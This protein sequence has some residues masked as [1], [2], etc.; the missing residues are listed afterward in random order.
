M[1]VDDNLDGNVFTNVMYEMPPEVQR[2]VIY[3]L[4]E[5]TSASPENTVL[6]TQRFPSGIFDM[7]QN[8]RFRLANRALFACDISVKIFVQSVAKQ[9]GSLVF[10]MS[11]MARTPTNIYEAMSGPHVVLNAGEHVSGEIVIPYMRDTRA[12]RVQTYGSSTES[13]DFD[14]LQANLLV[15]S[16]LRVTDA[17]SVKL[18]VAAQILNPVFTG[19]GFV[20]IPIV[21]QGKKE[22]KLEAKVDSKSIVKETKGKK[23]KPE[24]YAEAAASTLKSIA[25]SMVTVSKIVGTGL[26]VMAMMGLS[27]PIVEHKITPV[28]NVQDLFGPNVDGNFYGYQM[29]S[30]Q[31]AKNIAHPLVFGKEDPMEIS[32]ICKRPGLAG[33]FSWSISNTAGEL[34]CRIPI[35]PGVVTFKDVNTVHHTP[36]SML[37]HLFRRYRGS[38]NFRIRIFATKFHAGQLEIIANYGSTDDVDSE[39]RA[40]CCHRAVLDISN[41]TIVEMN[42]GYFRNAP[43]EECTLVPF[44][45]YI[46]DCVYIRCLAPLNATGDVTPEIEATVEV[47]SED[48][49]FGVPGT[50]IFNFPIV[51]QGIFEDNLTHTIIDGKVDLRDDWNNH[52]SVWDRF[53]SG[54]MIKNLRQV[55][56][57]FMFLPEDTVSVNGVD[58]YILY[59][60]IPWVEAAAS[61]FVFQIGG[62]RLST[63]SN[64]NIVSYTDR[65]NSLYT[66]SLSGYAEVPVRNSTQT[67]HF[68]NLPNM[69]KFGVIVLADPE[70]TTSNKGFVIKGDNK[71]KYSMSLADDASWGGLNYILYDKIGDFIPTFPCDMDDL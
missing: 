39:D 57:R 1:E 2:P 11:P 19:S 40:A 17:T 14:F 23:T 25:G 69:N 52:C 22:G 58:P 27:K 32:N 8:L 70:T 68:F 48:M 56:R 65:E 28:G 54:E 36:I 47:W 63:H 20:E 24:Q 42:V 61:L 7:V 44:N 4:P 50:G 64:S 45:S 62:W 30:Y 49:E 10:A 3:S 43:V 12:A 34:L 26:E 38:L 15:L 5:W 31:D 13:R 37:T 21:N 29:G 46:E 71:T 33:K 59:Q 9:A 35:T 67:S 53:V 60:R 66:A 18:I 16:P 41:T 55:T 51:N 6:W